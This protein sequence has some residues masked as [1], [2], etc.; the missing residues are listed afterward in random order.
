MAAE[1]TQ[2]RVTCPSSGHRAVLHGVFEYGNLP[3]NFWLGVRTTCHNGVKSQNF[4]LFT[5]QGRGWTT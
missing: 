3:N 4:G 2:P 5:A 1:W